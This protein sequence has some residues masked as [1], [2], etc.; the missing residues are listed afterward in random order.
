[1]IP[2]LR[3]AIFDANTQ[4]GSEACEAGKQNFGFGQEKMQTSE[5]FEEAKK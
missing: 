2:G 4:L 1:M 3:E 5:I